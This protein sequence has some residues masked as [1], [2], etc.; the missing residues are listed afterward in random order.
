MCWSRYFVKASKS[1]AQRDMSWTGFQRGDDEVVSYTCSRPSNF[2]SL[3][4]FANF[5]TLIIKIWKNQV[6]YIQFDHNFTLGGI[7][8]HSD[9]VE[10]G[11]QP[12]N[13]GYDK[14]FCE[15]SAN[16]A[17]SLGWLAF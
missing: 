13:G 5:L 7:F 11:T 16:E 2:C 1:Q 12:E 6:A 10:Q 4:H 3:V 15:K 14:P 9:S 17:I 8:D